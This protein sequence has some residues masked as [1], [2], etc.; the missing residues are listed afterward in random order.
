MQICRSTLRRRG[1]SLV[2]F[3]FGL[4]P[5]FIVSSCKV[6]SGGSNSNRSSH[7]RHL[8]KVGQHQQQWKP[9][10]S[11]HLGSRECNSSDLQHEQQE[12]QTSQTC[13]QPCPKHNSNWHDHPALP[14]LPAQTDR[15]VMLN[16]AGTFGSKA[17]VCEVINELLRASRDARINDEK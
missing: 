7:Q 10:H 15:A 5:A 1:Q 17:S 14:L 11:A 13:F 8:R 16:A 3:V 2:Q 4:T 12:F 6:Q 9:P